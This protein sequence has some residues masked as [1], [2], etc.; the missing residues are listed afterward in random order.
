[1][2]DR[3]LDNSMVGAGPWR[4]DHGSSGCNRQTQTLV[5]TPLTLSAACLPW[6]WCEVQR[7]EEEEQE[8]EEQVEEGRGERRSLGEHV[9]ES[10]R[11][12]ISEWTKKI[13]GAN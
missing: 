11:V 9:S 6:S 7:R 2:K 13:Q 10:E 4:L 12:R 5:T 1:M 8:E 3:Y